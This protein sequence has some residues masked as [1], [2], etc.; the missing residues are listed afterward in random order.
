MQFEKLHQNEFMME[1]L[2]VG[3]ENVYLRKGEEVK[4]NGERE[5]RE[6]QA[7]WI[8]ERRTGEQGSRRMLRDQ[9]KRQGS[10]PQIGSSAT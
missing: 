2:K 10:G 7:R 9:V 1:C 6:T 8:G 5:E 4:D 3:N